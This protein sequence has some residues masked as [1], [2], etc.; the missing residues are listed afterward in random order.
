[1][2]DNPP[3]ATQGVDSR[4]THLRDYWKIVW[5]ARWTVVAVTFVV[6]GL[7][8]VWT[9]TRPKIYRATATIEVQPQANRVAAGRD[10]SGLG[11]SGYGW[12]AEEKY[13]NTQV[14]IIQSRKIAE[15]AFDELQL[16]DHEMYA[17]LDRE[18]AIEAFRS[19]ISAIPR[20]E[21][22]LIE[23]SIAGT[24]PAAIT[25]WVNAIARAY[26]NHNYMRAK[27]NVTRALATFEDQLAKFQ[28][29]VTEAESERFETLRLSETFNSEEQADI[30]KERLR[31][32]NGELNLTQIEMSRLGEKLE[33][34]RQLQGS[35]ADLMSITELAEDVTL[36]ELL[37]EKVKLERALESA[38][39][40]LRP[41]HQ[42]YQKTE[43]E[44]DKVR[45]RIQDRVS[46][47]LGTL[48]NRYDLAAEHA[49]YLKGE[50]RAAEQMSVAVA[51]G[52]SGYEMKKSAAETK[53]HLF[54]LIARSISEVRIGEDLM[55]N[56]VSILDAAT[57]PRFPVKPRKRVNLLIGS[58]MGLFLGIAAAF[59]LD[60]LDNT[61]RT[62]EDIE[63]YLGL[64]VLGLIPKI[65]DDGITDRA[66]KE[67]YQSLRTSVIFSSKN[68]QRKVILF[69]STGPQEGKSSTTAKLGEM[70]AQAGERVIIVDCDLRRPVQNLIHKAQ[71]D[72]GVT[73]YV[74]APVEAV[75]LQQR[76]SWSE[77]VK[78]VGP[79]NLHLLPSGPIPPSPPELLG[80][81]RF[82]ALIGDLRESY[83]WV[84]IDSPPASSLADS[85]LLAALADM[86][87]LVVRHA[88]TDRD[89]VIK[90]VQRLRAVNSVIAGA[91]LNGVDLERSY[92]KDYYY[93]AAYYYTD[94]GDK[95]TGRRRRVE[96]KANVG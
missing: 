12:F 11:V 69:T 16:Q 75:G 63:K 38:K 34:I 91:V 87:V 49:D 8:A 59:F 21:T 45:Q 25:H 78:T 13:H 37:S 73:N 28:E 57:I 72:S 41:G 18:D 50:I 17:E 46:V 39:V 83:D 95:K 14:E 4:E 86:V 58:V 5:Q 90:T 74:A 61:F 40:E 6:I 60:Y 33:R 77:F 65:R 52:R 51:Q 76:G 53:K 64:S 81:E 30:I 43:S 55:S 44:L 20:R 93:A 10:I 56:N 88:E 62:P 68:H 19:Q 96:S 31:V 2:M 36:R 32:Y 22:G 27:E 92:N 71:R 70:L 29:E 3:V 47:I 35:Q 48:Q 66:V 94:E 1:M 54:D 80:S 7:T 82:A 23:V 84:L 15:E 89:L 79:A 85:T 42:Q 67:A 26:E 9:F 24:D